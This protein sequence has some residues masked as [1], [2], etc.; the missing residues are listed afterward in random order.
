MC[1]AKCNRILFLF[2][3]AVALTGLFIGNRPLFA[4]D[5]D[6]TKKT[7]KVAAK[8]APIKIGY[9]HGGRTHLFYRAY[10]NGFFENEHANV[11]LTT[12][13]LRKDG[14]YEVP[15]THKGFTA[16]SQDKKHF[17]RMTGTEI[18]DEMIKG[19][20][21]G[22]TIGEASF[23]DAV[24]K[25]KPIVAVAALGHDTKERPGHAFVLRKGLVVKK[26]G[27][28][29]GKTFTSRRSGP[30]DALL[31]REF[32]LSEGLK[33]SDVKIIDDMYDDKLFESLKS[34]AVDGGYY[35]LHWVKK[36]VKNDIGYV[37]RRLD[38]VN[39]EAS[40]ALLVFN[41][42]FVRD[43]REIVQ[44]IVNAYVKRIRFEKGLTEEKRMKPTEFGLQMVNYDV[45]GMNIP[46]YD[47]PPVIRVQLLSLV[48]DLMNKH[49]YINKK[50]EIEKFVDFSFVEG[51]MK[52]K[53]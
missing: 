14:L 43:N 16:A 48:Q 1:S 34:G 45:E 53:K 10:I 40:L 50:A 47:L 19:N 42:D 2:L 11:L 15:K 28:L 25:G 22:G 30:V 32:V 5:N 44:R 39:P 21:D 41:G 12:K 8:G 51:A 9:F 4:K 33:L 13:A 36:F 3:A 23:I 38:W 18:V 6:D 52:E 31:T 49:G 7:L 20:L 27:D 26:P 35:H 29:K 46:Q 17:G 24:S 37:Y